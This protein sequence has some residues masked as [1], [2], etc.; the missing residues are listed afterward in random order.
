M[1]I[2]DV[3]IAARVEQETDDAYLITDDE[4]RFIWVPKN[5]VDVDEDAGVII[6]PPWLAQDRGL[7]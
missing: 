4:E 2:S 7:V 5:L 3:E 6:M 1:A